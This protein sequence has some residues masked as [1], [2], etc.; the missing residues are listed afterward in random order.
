MFRAYGAGYTIGFWTLILWIVLCGTYL[1]TADTPWDSA[2]VQRLEEGRKLKDEQ[3]RTIAFWWGALVNLGGA[4]IL[5]LGTPLWARRLKSPPSSRQRPGRSSETDW[6]VT[7][8][9]LLLVAVATGVLRAPRLDHSLTNDEEWSWRKI[10]H[11]HWVTSDAG[12]HVF[13]ETSWTKTLLTNP[14]MNN[15]TLQTALS[16]LANGWWQRME[17]RDR[18]E[19]SEIAMRLPS[20]AAGIAS[21]VAIGILGTVA[22]GAR[23]GLGAAV[24]LTLSPWH[25]RYAVEAR[26]YSLMIFLLIVGLLSSIIAIEK[27]QLRWWLLFGICQTCYLLAFPGAVYVALAHCILIMATILRRPV[28]DKLVDLSRFFGAGILSVMLFMGTQF[29]AIKQLAKAVGETTK[30]N[31]SIGFDWV[32][33]TLSHLVAGIPWECAPQTFHNGMSVK[34]GWDGQP[35]Y[36]WVVIVVF[37]L[38]ALMGFGHMAV[39][40]WR[41]RLATLPVA[42]GGLLAVISNIVQGTVMF[43]WYII[44]VLVPFALCVGWAADRVATPGTR[45]SAWFLV[46]TLGLF[47]LTVAEPLHRI[48]NYQ[49]QPIRQVV[50]L[51]RGEA[52]LPSDGDEGTPITATFCTS[53]RQALSYDP[54]VNLLEEVED[55]DVVVAKAEENDKPL[56]VYFCDRKRAE[57]EWPELL[58]RVANGADFE[59]TDVVKGMEAMFRYTI[60]RWKGRPEE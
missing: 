6:G 17:N 50:E 54:Q 9:L 51:V 21:V 55:L 11:G 44:Y 24:V 59:Q 7:I 18:S 4:I 60:Y 30:W 43:G 31:H 37:P 3:V 8:G 29:V 48:S 13:K 26:G 41:S 28:N 36:V 23:V 33:D 5:A 40:D 1:A 15:H 45:R 12:K 10:G 16:R 53:A 14:T 58:D 39:V 47:G 35:F 32:L 2:I 27:R 20:F 56:L 46:L 25:L 49:R 19:F 22:G 38:V 57:A 34:L 42:I 52:R